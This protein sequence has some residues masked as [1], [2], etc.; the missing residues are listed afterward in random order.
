MTVIA[1]KPPADDDPQERFLRAMMNLLAGSVRVVLKEPDEQLAKAII[2]ALATE[3]RQLTE[4]LWDGV[5]DR[6]G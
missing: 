2:A 4:A 3:F 1:F 5:H 6:S